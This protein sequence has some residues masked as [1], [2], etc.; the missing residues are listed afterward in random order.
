M[1]RRDK[2]PKFLKAQHR[3]IRT[4]GI[5]D[6]LV[7]AVAEYRAKYGRDVTTTLLADWLGWHR[8]T[9]WRHL[10]ELIASGY[11][12]DDGHPT[13]ALDGLPD[14]TGGHVKVELRHLPQG[15]LEATVI[16]LLGTWGG[17]SMVRVFNGYA[18]VRSKAMAK[19]L[20][21][22][23]RTVSDVLRRLASGAT[24]GLRRRMRQGRDCLR[25]TWIKTAKRIRGR[26]LRVRLL[27]ERVS[28]RRV[29]RADERAGEAAPR[30]KQGPRTPPPPLDDLLAMAQAA[31][32]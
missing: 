8:A 4:L 18:E 17:L 14:T 2:R 20:A 21:V 11:L 25:A 19:F 27:P 13:D 28:Q 15:V 5:A 10:S 6:A 26:C 31:T 30:A 16:G 29:Q 23:P 22:H 3:V 1:H 32:A 24:V 12:D 7:I 9:A